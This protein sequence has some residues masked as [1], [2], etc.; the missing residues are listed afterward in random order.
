MASIRRRLSWYSTVWLSSLAGHF[1]RVVFNKSTDFSRYH[2]HHSDS[3]YHGASGQYRH[4]SVAP[5][6]CRGFPDTPR[7]ALSDRLCRGAGYHQISG[8]GRP[9]KLPRERHMGCDESLVE[10]CYPAAR[11]PG[12]L[13]DLVGWRCYWSHYLYSVDSDLGSQTSRVLTRQTNLAAPVSGI[14]A[15]CHI[16]YLHKR[17]GTRSN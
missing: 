9:G 8:S 14:H 2:K 7:Y 10:R 4:G 16:F 17:M 3:K 12:P 15:G 11:L 5:G 13:V 1:A 6:H